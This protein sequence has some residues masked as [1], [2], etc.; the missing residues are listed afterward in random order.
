MKRLSYFIRIIETRRRV[1][2]T[3]TAWNELSKKKNAIRVTLVNDWITSEY[4]AT[5]MIH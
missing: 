5:L 4:R 2:G 1:F 3:A